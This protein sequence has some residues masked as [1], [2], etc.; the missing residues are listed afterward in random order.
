MTT[1]SISAYDLPERVISYDI[2]MELMHPRRTKMI[3]ISLELVPTVTGPL[4]KALDLGTGT[5]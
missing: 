1:E 4:L 5:G 3:D 2:D